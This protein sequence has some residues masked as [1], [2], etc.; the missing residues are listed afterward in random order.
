MDAAPTV[1]RVLLSDRGT[2]ADPA[3][4]APAASRAGPSRD[5]LGRAFLGPLPGPP[6]PRVVVRERCRRAAGTAGSEGNLHER[7]P[8]RGSP[9][10]GPAR[11]L[12]RKRPRGH[13]PLGV[14]R[15]RPRPHSRHWA[16]R[17]PLSRVSGRC[18]VRAIQPRP[19]PRADL[20][21]G[22]VSRPRDGRRTAPTGA[23]L[24]VT[25]PACLSPSHGGDLQAR[26]RGAPGCS[27]TPGPPGSPPA[28]LT[29]KAAR[30][31]SS[32]PCAGASWDAVLRGVPLSCP[33]PA[34][35]PLIDRRS[36]T[37]QAGPWGGGSGS[38]QPLLPCGTRRPILMLGA[39]SCPCAQLG[40]SG[41]FRRPC[42]LRC[43]GL[44][45]RSSSA[46]AL[47]WRRAPGLRSY[48]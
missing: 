9:R 18:G 4:F 17:W 15:R 13:L 7:G 46:L 41:C 34:P 43:P 24:W 2:W 20:A 16:S 11:L 1:G 19:C 45:L 33:G 23:Q 44:H 40:V 26:F 12:Q 5:G 37:E 42:R 6:G 38:V 35:L 29:C 28:P 47:R 36:R 21:R 32:S 48:T 22:S 31:R 39:R 25:S 3:G 10:R 30:R 27:R 14:W 8:E